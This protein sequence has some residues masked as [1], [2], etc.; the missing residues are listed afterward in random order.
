MKDEE[1][2]YAL[3]RSEIDSFVPELTKHLLIVEK[4]PDNTKSLE[5]LMRTAHSLKGSAKILSFDLMINLSHAMEE[6]FMAAKRGEIK[7]SPELIDNLLHAV[8]EVATLNEAP[9]AEL[10]SWIETHES[11]LLLLTSQIEKGQ[12]EL[13]KSSSEAV[14]DKRQGSIKATLEEQTL[15]VQAKELNKLMGLAAE[16]MVDSSWL[17]PYRE[18]LLQL[19]LD[20]NT[21]L[22]E[23]E[24]LRAKI[25]GDLAKESV[26]SS[27]REL[28]QKTDSF[29]NAFN[30][31]LTELDLFVRKNAT[32]STRFYEEVIQIRMC[33]FAD[34]VEPMPR[35][36]REIAQELGKSVK[37][38]IKGKKRP[39]DREIIEK[40]KTPLAHL[41]RNAIDHGIESK[42]ERERANK[43]LEGQILLEARQR[44]G[45]VE[46]QLSDD[47]RGIN[48]E[49]L[50]RVLIES[51]VLSKKLTETMSEDELSQFLFEPGLTTK[52]S[53]S[54]L[55]G[56]GFGLDLVKES[57]RQV[58]GHIKIET[59]RGQGFSLTLYLPLTLSLLNC[60]II[61]IGGQKVALPLTRI[62]RA[63]IVNTKEIK[64]LDNRPYTIT[65]KQTIHLVDGSKLLNFPQRSG[66]SSPQ[67]QI[68]VL[69]AA[70]KMFGLIVD[71]LVDEKELIVQEID[72]R[73][74]H[75]ED[76]LAGAILED[77]SLLYILDVDELIQTIERSLLKDEKGK[78]ILV[79]DDSLTCLETLKERLQEEGYSVQTAENGVEALNM[80]KMKTF[81]LII[82]DLDM[83]KLSGVELVR[84]LRQSG[85]YKTL[86]IIVISNRER[87]EERR[88]L[89]SAGVDAYIGKSAIHGKEIINEVNRLL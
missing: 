1:K 76:V 77:G 87:D 16:A 64:Y 53:V 46:I 35:M 7:I 10:P 60:L 78:E 23:L 39:I 50:E 43:P 79:V 89:L 73:L 24:E 3:F 29:Y 25:A 51:E 30:R 86:P 54:T 62:A 71:R 37:L 31:R 57:V 27:V 72:P 58:G 74:G 75:I 44:G 6:C 34:L 18:S 56:R 49:Q 19:R 5:A 48:R 66:A 63:E 59:K 28:I 70:D 80:I 67:K 55:S 38:T 14:K 12:S 40:L 33:P 20:Q 22:K 42:E 84:L 61:E 21:L 41:L 9:S 88:S 11:S 83:P 4:E 68:V 81:D 47:G 69:Q 17:L 2:L 13:K 52:Q 36:C 15:K 65:Q 82:T 85:P 8:D 26:Q 32:L 45:M